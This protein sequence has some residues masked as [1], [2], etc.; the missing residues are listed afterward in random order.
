MTLPLKQELEY[1]KAVREDLAK[2]HA[3]MFVAIQGTDI[4]GI[5]SD[6]MAA[7]RALYPKYEQG[8]VFIQKIKAG[9]DAH[10]GI[11]HT[12]GLVALE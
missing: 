12:P 1:Y 11:F 10:I 7:A 5:Y 4:L 3:G 2:E 6:Y 8:S 9:R